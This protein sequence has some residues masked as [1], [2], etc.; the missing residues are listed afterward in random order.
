ML[1]TTNETR[2]IRIQK[3]PVIPFK[4][5]VF[6]D[7]G[8]EFIFSDSP[9]ALHPRVYKHKCNRCG[10]EVCLRESFPQTVYEELT[11]EPESN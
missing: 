9:V 8:G 5:S 4:V 11:S 2:Q 3:T 6:C 1:E 10:Y 7:C